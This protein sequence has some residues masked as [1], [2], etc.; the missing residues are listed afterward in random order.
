MTQE[1]LRELNEGIASLHEEGDVRS[2]AIDPDRQIQFPRGYL[3]TLQT[4]R[5]FFPFI[6]DNVVREKVILHMLHRDTLHWLW[7]KTDIAYE[8][9]AMIVKF[10][11]V[12]L[13]VI[14]EALVKHVR[15]HVADA[16]NSVRGRIEVLHNDGVIDQQTEDD[17]KDLWAT[18][19][20]IHI[21]TRPDELATYSNDNYILWHDAVKRLIEALT[22]T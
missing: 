2:L 17:L 13:A 9:R 1:E 22:P 18:R 4:Y 19:N 21:D 7:L 5:G 15:P 16:Q 3:R 14:L 6:T 8:A 20:R 10:Q 12:N 11:L